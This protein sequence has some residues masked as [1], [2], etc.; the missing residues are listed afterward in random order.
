MLL[1]VGRRIGESLV[2]LIRYMTICLG[3]CGKG[4]ERGAEHKHV[5]AHPSC[6]IL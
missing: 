2:A 1:R 5:L 6:R 3:H 4:E